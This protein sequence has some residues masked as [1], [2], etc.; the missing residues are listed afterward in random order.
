LRFKTLSMAMMI[1]DSNIKILEIYYGSFD[2]CNLILNI[3]NIV[4]VTKQEENA[5]LYIEENEEVKDFYIYEN[6]L[7][8]VLK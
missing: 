6:T 2:K 7:S 8:V 1:D 4:N 5:L 3:K